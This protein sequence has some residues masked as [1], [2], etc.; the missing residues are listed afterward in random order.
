MPRANHFFLPGYIWHITH[1]CHKREFLLKFE[2]DKKRWIY[3]LF[4]AKKR[5]KLHVLNYNVT[6]N[7]IHLIVFDDKPGSVS[8]SLQLIAGRVGQEFNN[9]KKR[10]GA[11]W[12]DRFHATAIDT[13]LYLMQC[14]NYIDLNM[15]RNGTVNHPR[16][17]QFGG[18]NE[19][20]TPKSRYSIIDRNRLME[21]IK[22][23]DE[24]QFVSSY[25]ASLE[26]TI[27]KDDYQFDPKWSKSIAV[28]SEKYI[29][30]IKDQL[31]I[32]G[33]KKKKEQ[34]DDVWLLN[35]PGGSYKSLFGA[36]K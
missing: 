16:E 8:K 4:E 23:V 34:V 9:R 24:E 36:K 19:I 7:H 5:Y 1:R 22:E 14:M 11:F 33:N 27:K 26:K 12:E 28:G 31:G 21:L 17:W 35:E 2:K 3:W 13:E 32:K 6:S 30:G 15:V 10:K 18:Y 29:E 25:I 20:I